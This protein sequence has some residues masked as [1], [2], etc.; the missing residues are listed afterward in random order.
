MASTAIKLGEAGNLVDRLVVNIRDAIIA[1]DFAP[2]E[3]IRIK[4]VADR[5]GVS[6][7]PV[8]EAL[9]RLLATRIVISEPNRGYFVAPAPTRAE[10]R[11]FIEFREL[12][13]TSAVRL[14]FASVKDAD[15]RK[16]ERLNARMS[17][18]AEDA[19]QP[20]HLVSWAHLNG[21]FHAI[22]V[23]L[24]R[25]AFISDQHQ[26]LSF[27]HMHYQLSL[28]DDPDYGI[29]SALA[30]EHDALIAALKARDQSVFLERLSA[31]INAAEIGTEQSGDEARSD[32]AGRC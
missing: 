21:E 8:R 6:L 16:L 27:V 20:K 9:A 31:H 28:M 18:V 15:I 4:T 26:E 22:L 19:S 2:G 10:F 5:Y 7:I 24:A 11:Q 1:G 14:G 23:G 25:N 17:K 32:A 12:F 29:L 30:E 3:H 13:E